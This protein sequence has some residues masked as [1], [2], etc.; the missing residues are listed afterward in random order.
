MPH[1]RQVSSIQV[2]P[3]ILFIQLLLSCRLFATEEYLRLHF[4]QHEERKYICN[5]PGCDKTFIYVTPYKDHLKTH[6]GIRDCV[7]E[8]CSA[9]FSTRNHLKNHIKNV[10]SGNNFTCE[11]CSNMYKRPDGLRTHFQRHHKDLSK[12]DVTQLMARVRDRNKS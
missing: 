4:K 11:L 10:H 6:T 7:C 5:F 2:H 12:E 9:A 3:L 1:L 8:I